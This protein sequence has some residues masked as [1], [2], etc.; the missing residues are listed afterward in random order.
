MEIAETCPKSLT[1]PH[2]GA[3][4][5]G[6]GARWGGM[7][8]GQNHSR[9]RSG[10]QFAVSLHKIIQK[11]VNDDAIQEY[12]LRK[13]TQLIETTRFELSFGRLMPHAACNQTRHSRCGFA[14]FLPVRL[15]MHFSQCC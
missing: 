6:H 2:S 13:Q 11:A 1:A 14:R 12:Q 7:G 4:G 15:I 3:W 5:M 9:S 8:Q 10:L